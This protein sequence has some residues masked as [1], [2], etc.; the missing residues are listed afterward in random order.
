MELRVIAPR[1]KAPSKYDLFETYII[2]VKVL[3][4]HSEG[5]TGKVIPITI[6]RLDFKSGKLISSDAITFQ[7]SVELFDS[8]NLEL[9]FYTD[10]IVSKSANGVVLKVVGIYNT[11]LLEKVY[12][13]SEILNNDENELNEIFTFNYCELNKWLVSN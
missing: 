8:L 12:K 7:K 5:Q 11:G 9:P 2:P 1:K 6:E 3:D 13:V 10:C 4:I